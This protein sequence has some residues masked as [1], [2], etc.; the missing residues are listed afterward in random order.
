MFVVFVVGR[1]VNEALIRG[2]IRAGVNAVSRNR[3]LETD[4]CR[5]R[6]F[7]NVRCGPACRR[8]LAP[9][10][11]LYVDF[12][13][14]LFLCATSYGI[15]ASAVTAI[16][17]IP[18]QL[19]NPRFMTSPLLSSLIKHHTSIRV[20]RTELRLRHWSSRVAECVVGHRTPPRLTPLIAA[21]SWHGPSPGGMLP[22]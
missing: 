14:G 3:A 5:K 17:T 6:P 13:C 16:A 8:P 22:L 18:M 21:N 4:G 20:A 2:C 15:C 7:E 12:L 10:Y 9:R 1:F 11:A 19:K